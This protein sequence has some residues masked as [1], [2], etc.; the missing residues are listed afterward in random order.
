MAEKLH[1]ESIAIVELDNQNSMIS[2]DENILYSVVFDQDQPPLKDILENI[3]QLPNVYKNA[4]SLQISKPI[5]LIFFIF[6]PFRKC[7][8][9]KLVCTI[10]NLSN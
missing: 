2:K 10:I 9:L 4:Y 5:F 7:F 8:I 1:Q 6:Y 3:Q